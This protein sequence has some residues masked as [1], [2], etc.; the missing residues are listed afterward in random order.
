M[1]TLGKY[2]NTFDKEVLSFLESHPAESKKVGW[3]KPNIVRG[4]ITPA[5]ASGDVI[6]RMLGMQTKIYK[7]KMFQLFPGHVMVQ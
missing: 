1:K 3:L 5:G 4:T 6:K 2:L 7:A